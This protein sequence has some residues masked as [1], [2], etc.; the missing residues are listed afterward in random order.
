[1][2]SKL[3]VALLKSSQL[4]PMDKKPNPKIITYFP[5]L[6]RVIVYELRVIVYEAM[7]IVCKPMAIV[8]EPRTLPKITRIA[9]TEKGMTTPIIIR[10]K[11]LTVARAKTPTYSDGLRGVKLYAT[12]RRIRSPAI[13]V[14]SVW[15]MI[16]SS[17]TTANNLL[18]LVNYFFRIVFY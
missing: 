8:Y 1:M 7:V 14:P 13:I 18:V 10:D 5:T 17:S 4:T 3:L 6:V 15:S 2:Y 16:F 12:V 11:L 9:E